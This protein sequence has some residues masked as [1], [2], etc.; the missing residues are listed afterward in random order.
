MKSFL[1]LLN[2]IFRLS[3]GLSDYLQSV[4]TYRSVKK[5]E[6]L[7]RPGEVARYVYWLEKG[8]LRGYYIKDEEE[9]SSWFY[10]ENSL[11]TSV[12][13]FFRHAPSFEY[14]VALEDCELLAMT[15]EDFQ[16]GRRAF[17]EYNYVSFEVLAGYYMQSEE[18]LVSLRRASAAEKIKYIMDRHPDWMQRVPKKYIASYLDLAPEALSRRMDG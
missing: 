6:I 5:R 8:F 14:I 1:E 2:S 18:R 9:V 4:I 12:S 3:D 10:G 16:A 11:V 7:L 17:M 15:F 13:S